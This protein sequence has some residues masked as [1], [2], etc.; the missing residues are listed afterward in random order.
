MGTTKGSGT[1]CQN[2]FREVVGLWLAGRRR[3]GDIEPVVLVKNGQRREGGPQ[4]GGIESGLVSPVTESAGERSC[5]IL[6]PPC[7]LARADEPSSSRSGQGSFS[8][9]TKALAQGCVCS[10]NTQKQFCSEMVV[11][12]DDYLGSATIHFDMRDHLH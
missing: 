5:V 11:V 2:S 7:Q 4:D 10:P 1:V 9:S 12:V 6:Y 3:P 8:M